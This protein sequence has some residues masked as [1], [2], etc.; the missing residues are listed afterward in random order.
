MLQSYCAKRIRSFSCSILNQGIAGDTTADLV[1]RLVPAEESQSNVAVIHVGMNDWRKG[2]SSSAFRDNLSMI[3]T[4]LSSSRRRAILATITPDWNGPSFPL[5]QSNRTGTS[6][7]IIEYN[8]IIR[9]LAHEHHVRVADANSLWAQRL[10]PVWKGLKDAIHPNAMGQEIICEALYYMISREHI[11]VVWPFNG[12]YTACNYSCPYCYVP[13]SVNKGGGMSHAIDEWETAF[14]RSFGPRQYLTFYLSFG[15]PTLAPSFMQVLEMIGSHQQWDVMITSNLSTHLDRL[16]LLRLT[17]EGRL[18]INA[19]FHPTET[20]RE[21]FI[22]KLILLRGMGVECPVIYVAYP[23]L[24]SRLEDDISFFSGQ[25]FVVHVRRFRGRHQGKAYPESYTDEEKKLVA[26]FMDSASIRYMLSN[27]SSLGRRSFLG[28]HH[29]LVAENGDIELCDEYPGERNLGNVFR[30]DIR[31]STIP[32]PFPGPVSLG[33]VDDIANLVELEYEELEGNHVLSFARQGGVFFNG[34][35]VIYPF[36]DCEFTSTLWEKLFQLPL[37]DRVSG[38]AWF[39]KHRLWLFL[40]ERNIIRIK[41]F[42]N[43]KLRIFKQHSFR[44]LFHFHS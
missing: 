30:G 24:L 27:T 31:L 26:R 3:I 11:T 33:A 44:E 28:I 9:A 25:G 16:K 4:R 1:K 39:I 37:P 32:Q 5:S 29:A 23:P 15:E 22:E 40:L 34:E 42:F 2:I 14:V 36:K 18:N 12:R 10:S 8:G 35:N 13:T 7:E 38:F 17:Q 41:H 19:S 20:T 43:G 6:P 21:K